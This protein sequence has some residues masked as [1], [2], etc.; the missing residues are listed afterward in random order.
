MKAWS[1]G[2]AAA[3]V[4]FSSA[5]LADGKSSV[6]DRAKDP[7]IGEASDLHVAVQRRLIPIHAAMADPLEQSLRLGVLAML[8]AAD[9]EHSKQSSLRFDLAYTYAQLDNWPRAAV[10]YKSALAD[11]PNDARAEDAWFELA[12]ACGHTGDHECEW[13][14]YQVVLARRTQEGDR[15]TPLL[16]LAETDMHNGDLHEAI[17]GYREV[18]RLAA[19]YDQ[20]RGT[21]PLAEWGL[22]VALDRAGEPT[23]GEKEARHAQEIATS[24]QAPQLLQSKGVFF[25]PDYEVNW[26]LAITAGAM[27]RTA[28]SPR[29][30]LALWQESERFWVTWVTGAIKTKDHWLPIAKTRL[31]SAQLER[32]RAEAAVA[33]EPPPEPKVHSHSEG[34]VLTF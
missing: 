14:A 20:G 26:Y 22:A 34:P 6:W 4:C 2:L 8:Q 32:Q 16:N 11:F 3:L 15:M 29:V 13:K 10:V 23:E 5:A 18:V 33:K 25:V 12:I 21:Y 1:L 24:L 17:A 27:A 30:R 9:A 19:L 7:A 31:A 28:Q